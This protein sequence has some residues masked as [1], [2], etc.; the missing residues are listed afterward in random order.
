MM[1][2]LTIPWDSEIHKRFAIITVNGQKVKVIN[3]IGHS[4]PSL[5]ILECYPH[6]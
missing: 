4:D 3:Y 2:Y 1:I 6:D 5:I